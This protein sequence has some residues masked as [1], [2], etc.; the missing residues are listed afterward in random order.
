MSNDQ[1]RS[2]VTISNDDL[3]NMEAC[4]LKGHLMFHNSVP[5]FTTAVIHFNM[6]I[7]PPPFM[8]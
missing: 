8:Q 2:K 1:W 4:K 6:A 7:F 3:Q 5:V